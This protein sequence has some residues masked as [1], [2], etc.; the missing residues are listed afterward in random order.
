MNF[1]C[2]S[3]RII[4][5]LVLITGC[6]SLLAAEQITPNCTKTLKLGVGEPW[7]P[8]VIGGPDNYSGIDIEITRL[9]LQKLNVC[10]EIVKLPS[11]ARGLQELKKGEIDFLNAASFTEER[12]LIGFYSMPYRTEAMRIFYHIHNKPKFKFQSVFDLLQKDFIG[13]VNLG[14]Y[15]GPEFEAMMSQSSFANQ[16][17]SVPSV[18]Q[19]MRML[20]LHHVDFVIED[21]VPGRYYIQQ[22]QKFNIEM[23]PIVVHDNPIY[24]LFSRETVS[25]EQVNQV[26]QAIMQ[27]QTNIDAVV[28]NYIF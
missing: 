1:Y 18:E 24:F 27:L 16:I 2:C 17:T 25:Q 22:Q 21:I 5:T 12:A 28:D 9:V 15:Y 20:E 11:S 26:N 7:P 14:A 3:L 8:F 4:A 13:V 6:F 10:L 19:R 23:L